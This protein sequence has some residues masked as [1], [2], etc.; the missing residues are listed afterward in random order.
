MR[1]RSSASRSLVSERAMNRPTDATRDDVGGRTAL[2]HDAVH[3]VARTQLLAQQTDRH[4]RDRHRVERV[5][6]DPRRGGGVRLL[7]LEDDVEVVDGET[8]RV[9][10]FGGEGVHHHRGVHVIEVAGVDQVDLAAAALLRTAC[11][12]GSP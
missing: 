4:L 7:A 3:E 2:E 11:R 10:S 9:E 6:P 12:A 1:T 8:E 5:D